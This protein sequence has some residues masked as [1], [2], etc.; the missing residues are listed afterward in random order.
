MR[1]AVWYYEIMCRN[2]KQLYNFEPHASSD[3]VLAAATQFVRKVS[4]FNKPSA[5]NEA[6][7]NSAIAE[8]AHITQ[9]LLDDLVT[10][11]A[12]RNRQVEA[13][14]A[15]ARAERRFGTAE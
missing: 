11:A 12:P 14:K 2:I 7:F 6:V 8:I 1:R 5:A 3:E 10:Q 4:G 13:A 9:H 15:R